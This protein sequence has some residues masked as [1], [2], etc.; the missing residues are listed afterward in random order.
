[1]NASKPGSIAAILNEPNRAET[2]PVSH[3]TP[4]VLVIP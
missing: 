1:M 3:V 2:R 4:Q